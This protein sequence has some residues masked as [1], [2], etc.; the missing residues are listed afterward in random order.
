MDDWLKKRARQAQEKRL[1]I[2]RVLVPEP[3]TIAGFYTL[4]MGQV[5][6]DELPHEMAR[7]LPST[8]RKASR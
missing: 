6:F 1:S 5:S 4:A 8:L 3:E 7:K 2:A